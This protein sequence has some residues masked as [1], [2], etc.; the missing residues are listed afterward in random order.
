MPNTFSGK[1]V[2]AENITTRVFGD[3]TVVMSLETLKTFYLNESAALIWTLLTEADS[4]DRIIDLVQE[5]YDVT[6]E[7]CTD[8]VNR[9]L[10]SWSAEKLIQ[11]TD[12]NV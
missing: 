7:E 6:P 4:I 5:H 11:F 1:P 8:E 3:E 12:N 10:E 9:L 2:I